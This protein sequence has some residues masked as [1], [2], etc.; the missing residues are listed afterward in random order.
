MGLSRARANGRLDAVLE[1]SEL[2]EFVDMKLK[3]YSSGMLVRLAFS[4]MVQSDADILLIDEVLAVGDA[5]FQQKCADVFRE[6]RDSD[7]TVVLVTHDM[8][9]V[10]DFCH[11]AMLLDDGNLVQIG[12]PGEVARSY[13]RLN[14]DRGTVDLVDGV[15]PGDTEPEIR[16]VDVWLA[17]A[18]GERT[19]NIEQGGEL[20]LEAVLEASRDVPGPSVGFMFTN[21]DGVDVFGF[22]KGL[23]IDRNPDVLPAGERVRLSGRIDNRLAAGRHVI[24]FWAHRNHNHGELLLYSPRLLDFVVFGTEITEGVVSLSHEIT[25]SPPTKPA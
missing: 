6:M 22:G 15:G 5:A 16:V 18:D 25:T 9:A 7:R 8:S 2:E 13:L 12:D 23:T 19:T 3:N 11:R 17:G 24:R 10:E 20:R 4:V 14:F 1:F 21:A